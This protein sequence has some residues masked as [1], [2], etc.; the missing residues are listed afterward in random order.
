MDLGKSPYILS[1]PLPVAAISSIADPRLHLHDPPGAGDVHK[2]TQSGLG[3]LV[4]LQYWRALPSLPLSGRV[5]MGFG[6]K[7]KGPVVIL[8]EGEEVAWRGIKVRVL[9]PVAPAAPTALP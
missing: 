6:A 9:A 4:A 7:A 1:A 8:D 5:P 2:E 3:L